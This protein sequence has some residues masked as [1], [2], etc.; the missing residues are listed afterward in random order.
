[1]AEL[2]IS[3]RQFGDITIF[4]MKG[5]ILF[6]QGNLTL[7]YAV[8]RLLS[9]GKKRILL[10]FSE[11]NFVDSG[12]IGELISDFTAVNREGGR[13]KLLNLTHRIKYLL[14]ITKLLTVFET[15]ENEAEAIGS[16]NQIK[17]FLSSNT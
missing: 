9:N 5:D 8:R 13:L 4:D 1:M 11:V 10:N 14:E 2:T 15:F 7:R 17:S 3:E 12:G 6:G 16:Y